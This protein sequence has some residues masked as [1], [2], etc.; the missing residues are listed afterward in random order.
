MKSAEEWAGE[1]QD[2][3]LTDL[4]ADNIPCLDLDELVLFVRR[5]QRDAVM[6]AAEAVNCGCDLASRAVCVDRTCCDPAYQDVMELL[7]KEP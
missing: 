1:V 7:P 6:A 4:A 5:V 2:S 3:D